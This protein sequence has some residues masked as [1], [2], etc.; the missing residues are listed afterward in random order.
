MDLPTLLAIETCQVQR[1]EVFEEKAGTNFGATK[2]GPI[3]HKYGFCSPPIQG[4]IHQ[5]WVRHWLVYHLSIMDG[6]AHFF[7][8]NAGGITQEGRAMLDP[9]VKAGIVTITNVIDDQL[10]PTWYRAQVS[11]PVSVTLLLCPKPP[12]NQSSGN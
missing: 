5:D 2:A 8:Y 10:Y 11:R 4:S 7:F 9:F 3:P 1:H 6:H 12:W